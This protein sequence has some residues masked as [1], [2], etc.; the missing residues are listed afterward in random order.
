MRLMPPDDIP[1]EV[2]AKTLRGSEARLFRALIRFYLTL[3]PFMRRRRR[4]R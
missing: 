4:T 1:P 3:F 2:W